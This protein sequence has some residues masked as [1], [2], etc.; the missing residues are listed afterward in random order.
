MSVG[1]YRIKN[2]INGK[3]YIG[4]SLYAEQRMRRHKS[5]LN[6]GKHHSIH[7]QRS[8]DKHGASAFEFELLEVVE[9]EN[10][11]AREQFYMDLYKPEFNIYPTA[12]SSFGYKHSEE[13]RLK[14]KAAQAARPKEVNTKISLSNK[15]KKR[16]KEAIENYRNVYRNKTDEEKLSTVTPMLKARKGIPVSEAGKGRIAAS[17]MRQ[18]KVVSPD[19]EEFEIENL[20]KFCKQ[21]GLDRTCMTRVS[22]GANKHHKGWK[23]INPR[24]ETK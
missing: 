7:L 14:Y 3:I 6:A 15:G 19:G 5:N 12:G 17:N 9:E 21:R 10:L 24:L 23:C 20:T 11:L 8:W 16:T 22:I 2:M 1:V 18:F 4:S 13:T